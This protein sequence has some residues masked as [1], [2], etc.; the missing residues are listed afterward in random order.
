MTTPLIGVAFSLPLLLSGNNDTPK[1][2]LPKGIS[3]ILNGLGTALQ[4]IADLF[5]SKPSKSGEPKFKTLPA[6]ARKEESDPL[7]EL[8]K[9][10]LPE[11]DAKE[12]T[13]TAEQ[14][15]IAGSARIWGD[16]HFI[17]AEGGKY[18]V[19]GEA[20]KT[21]N[22]LSDKDFQLNGTFD[23]YG[24]D[25]VQTVVGKAA[26]N[27]DG[28]YIEV[29]KS[30]RAHV[31]GVELK[32]GQRI[33]LEGGG[34]AERKGGEII[35][36]KGE[37]DVS[38]QSQGDHLNIDV[39]TTNAVADGV[40]PHGLLGQ[41]FDGDGKA[42]NG[43]SYKGA[44]GGGAI[45]GLNGEITDRGDTDAVKTYEVSNL[46]DTTFRNHN[47]GDDAGLLDYFGGSQ[48]YLAAL[49]GASLYSSLFAASF[50]GSFGNP[51]GQ[52]QFSPFG[53]DLRFL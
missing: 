31:N 28:N 33:D 34:I 38:F 20:G 29:D 6:F 18:D 36:K 25:G 46:W 13:R 15:P 3:Q 49:A 50:G 1:A 8:L 9:S 53:G 47:R 19:Q 16:P 43:D 2:S 42:R 21:Y 32:D 51:F 17:G 22:L 41:T 35:V 10:F 4:G 39:K 27:A 40:K 52:S 23:K 45:E 11:D 12:L 14:K 30:G 5:D 26:I 37:W 48:P 24:S 44:Q 7:T